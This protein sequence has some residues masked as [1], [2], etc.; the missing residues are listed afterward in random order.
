MWPKFG[1]AV[2]LKQ[3]AQSGR[4]CYGYKDRKGT[5]ARAQREPKASISTLK[6]QESSYS[7]MWLST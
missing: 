1:S 5:K 4:T 7:E 2:F 3:E 6:L